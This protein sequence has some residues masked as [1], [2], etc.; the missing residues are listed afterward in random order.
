[1]IMGAYVPGTRAIY[2]GF[3]GHHETKTIQLFGEF[4]GK[5]F[6]LVANFVVVCH[7]AQRVR[8]LTIATQSETVYSLSASFHAYLPILF[9]LVSRTLLFCLFVSVLSTAFSRRLTTYFRLLKSTNQSR[10]IF[11]SWLR[12]ACR[13]NE[14]RELHLS[15]ECKNFC[16]KRTFRKTFFQSKQRQFKENLIQVRR[17]DQ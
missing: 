14:R 7:I 16:K 1:M 9:C 13:F 10:P 6:R 11:S 2:V 5:L 8:W 4:G 3:Q 17:I 15:E 12:K